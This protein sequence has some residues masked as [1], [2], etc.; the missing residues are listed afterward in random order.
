[1]TSRNHHIHTQVI[2]V[3]IDAEKAP[4]RINDR[5][6]DLY[7]NRLHGMIE[8]VLNKFDIIDR[9][10]QLN[11]IEVELSCNDLNSLEEKIANQLFQQL[12]IALKD[13]LNDH[14]QVRQLTREKHHLE[15]ALF[16]LK[17]GLLPWNVDHSIKL[18]QIEFW[19]TEALDKSANQAPLF[20]QQ[21]LHS[22]QMFRRFVARFSMKMKWRL[23]DY[24]W[25]GIQEALQSFIPE[26]IKVDKSD[27]WKT[28]YYYLMKQPKSIGGLVIQLQQKSRFIKEGQSIFDKEEAKIEAS[29]VKGKKQE[30][31]FVRNAGVVL[32]NPFIESLFTKLKVVE[33]N[34]IKNVSK[35]I[36]LLHYTITGEQEAEEWNL[37]LLK[38][39]CGI[40][41]EEVIQFSGQLK[42]EEIKEIETLFNALISH[43]K[44]LK[45]TSVDGLRQTFLQ[46]NGRINQYSENYLLKVE[47]A[48]PD[49]LID[50]LPWG[51]NCIQ[52]PWM[53]RPLITEWA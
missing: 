34:K 35:A 29:K 8:K 37:P 2:E 32:L 51:F 7:Y 23:A 31:F 13:A 47:Q 16:Y 53:E 49:I 24:L 10:I 25:P 5:L 27:V 41:V 22:K 3:E 20:I 44:I 19:L 39:L 14:S 45:N 17:T 9:I 26:I 15:V 21:L 38:I 48:G 50:H 1:M 36:Q 43:W 40:H 28:I 12:S 18:Y 46:R 33:D 30:G 52:L 11:K 42:E 6:G 4:E